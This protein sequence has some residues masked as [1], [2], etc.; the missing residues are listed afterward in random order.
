MAQPSPR[1]LVVLA[2]IQG[3][4]YAATGVWGLVDLASFQAVTGPKTDLWLVRTVAVLVLVAGGVLLVAAARL[5][6]AFETLL[7][8]AGCALG[9][10][11]IDV[12]YVAAGTLRPVY[13]LDAAAEA[14]LA[15]LWGAALW[16]WRDDVTLWGG[17]LHGRARRPA[18]RRTPRT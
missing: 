14:V 4:F 16:R 17:E 6:V 10:A 3:V 18:T 1:W 12:A 2:A 7:L 15:L 13:L 5:R 9:L 8:A 11:A